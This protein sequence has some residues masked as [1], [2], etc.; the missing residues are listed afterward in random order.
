MYFWFILVKLKGY[1]KAK[2][3]QHFEEYNGKNVV[4]TKLEK[5][6]INK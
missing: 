6:E 4:K 2:Q 5:N 1:S 3:N